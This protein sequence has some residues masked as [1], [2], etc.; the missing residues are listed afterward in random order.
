MPKAGGLIWKTGAEIWIEKNL[1]AQKTHTYA[2][3]KKITSLHTLFSHMLKTMYTHTHVQKVYPKR[4]TG[5][6]ECDG[7][8][9]ASSVLCLGFD[10]N[11]HSMKAHSTTWGK[12]VCV[13][14]RVCICAVN[15]QSTTC[16]LAKKAK[17]HSTSRGVHLDACACVCICVFT[18]TCLA[19]KCVPVACVCVCDPFCF[20]HEAVPH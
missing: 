18:R 8:Q 4:Q 12:C 15:V 2:Q 16:L 10:T 5:G 7:S 19:C 3:A 1:C 14:V 13:Y 20:P 11:P 17:L 9:S 6:L